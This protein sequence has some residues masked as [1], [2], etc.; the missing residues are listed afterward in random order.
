MACFVAALVI[1]GIALVRSTAPESAI[2]QGARATATIE[3]ELPEPGLSFEVAA[4]P[5]QDDD[6]EDAEEGSEDEGESEGSDEPEPEKATIKVKYPSAESDFDVELITALPVENGDE[7]ANGDLL[8]EVSNRPMFVLEGSSPAVRSLS[9][10]TVGDDVAQLERA[11]VALGYNVGEV[12][13]TFD[14]STAAAVAAFYDDRGYSLPEADEKDL[15]DL[16]DAQV[17]LAEAQV[18]RDAAVVALT[19]ANAADPVQ[20]Q[21]DL[22]DLNKAQSELELSDTKLN[23][24]RRIEADLHDLV[25]RFA[26]FR[27]EIENN[28]GTGVLDAN[29]PESISESQAAELLFLVNDEPDDFDDFDEMYAEL[30]QESDEAFELLASAIVDV[31]DEE[32]ER[33]ILQ[34]EVDLAWHKYYE[35]PGTSDADDARTDIAEIDIEIGALKTQMGRL[36]VK[37]SP[38]LSI[39]EFV[40]APNLPGEI[41]DV[42]VDLRDEADGTMLKIKTG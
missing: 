38:R 7:V 19:A 2:A 36:A 21:E 6:A 31:A 26:R 28:I 35:E 42:E 27:A 18:K 20:A 16:E 25:A 5:V 30:D 39:D 33:E 40:F 1:A 13:D 12:D 24:L 15:E 37:T 10:G 22:F 17:K 4:A 14:G 8:V 34:G 29:D 23:N 41:D 3:T 11:L 9:V 32:S